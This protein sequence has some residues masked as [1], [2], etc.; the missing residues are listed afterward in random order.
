MLSWS[1]D[2]NNY[3]SKVHNILPAVIG[4]WL[5]IFW[6]CVNLKVQ[7][8]SFSMNTSPQDHHGITYTTGNCCAIGSNNQL[9]K[10]FERRLLDRSP[11]SFLC[12][13][14][15]NAHTYLSAHAVVLWRTPFRTSCALQNPSGHHN[16]TDPSS[17]KNSALCSIPARIHKNPKKHPCVVL[18]IIFDV[19][20]QKLNTARPETLIILK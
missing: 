4:D 12:C 5:V 1:M 9:G 11:T 3:F 7:D 16:S 14:C 8:W 13:C 15:P 20:K 18:E 19:L 17:P 2:T 6:W 10:R